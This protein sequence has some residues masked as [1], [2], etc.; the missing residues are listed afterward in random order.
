MPIPKAAMVVHQRAFG[1][2]AGS[3]RLSE[4][5]AAWM[6]SP[7]DGGSLLTTGLIPLPLGNAYQIVGRAL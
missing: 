1:F 7:S 5:L 6:P 4:R 3:T 2:R